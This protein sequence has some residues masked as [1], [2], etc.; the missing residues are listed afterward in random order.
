M[1]L[2]NQVISQI[3]HNIAIHLNLSRNSYVYTCFNGHNLFAA[4]RTAFFPHLIAIIAFLSFT[5]LSVKAQNQAPLITDTLSFCTQP[6]SPVTICLPFDDPNGDP[7]SITGGHTTFN[8]SLNFL[9]DT[10]VRYTPLPAF[11]GTDYVFLTLCDDQTPPACSQAVA[12]VHVGCLPP[13]AHN[14]QIAIAPDMVVINGNSISTVTGYNGVVFNALNNDD[15]VCSG[16]LTIPIVLNAPQNGSASVVGTAMLSYIPDAGFSGTDQFTYIACNNCPLCD[17][18]TVTI[19]VMPTSGTACDKDINDCTSPFNTLQL[20]PEF[21]NLT[22]SQITNIIATPLQGALNIPVDGCYTYIPDAT[23]TGIDIVSFIACSSSGLCDTTF[24]YITIDQSCGSNSPQANNDQVSTSVA[25]SVVIYPLSNDSDPEGG[26]LTM[27]EHTNP[28]HG[29]VTVSGNNFIYTPNAGFTG[30]DSFT[31]TICDPD[32]LCSQATISITVIA[33]C[34]NQLEYCTASFMNPVEICLQFCELAGESEVAVTDAFTT[35]NCSINLLNDTCIRYTPLP[36]FVGTDFVSIIACNGDATHCDTIQVTVSVGCLKPQANNDAALTDGTPVAGNVLSNDVELCDNVLIASMISAP[37][38]GTANIA[39]NGALSYTP[40]AGF[41]GI[42]YITYVACNTCSPPKC[43]TAIVAITVTSTIIVTPEPNILAQPDVVQT[44]YGTSVTI[45][46]LANDIGEDVSINSFSIPAHGAVATTPSGTIIYI[47]A[48]GYSGID[49]FLYQICNDNGECSQTLV[50]VLVLPSGNPPQAPIAHND[51]DSTGIGTPIGIH[52]L[53]NDNDP[54]NGNLLLSSTSTPTAGTASL[55]SG[56]VIN[57]TPPAGFSGIATFTYEV[58]DQQGLCDEAMVAVAV[59]V[60]YNNEAPIAQN[61]TR[62]VAIGIPATVD[63]LAND[64]DPD[65][66]DLTATII[67]IPANG[68]ASLNVGNGQVTYTPNATFEGIDYLVYMLCDDAI[69]ALCDTAYITFTVGNGNLPPAAQNDVA[70]THTNTAVNVAVLNNDEDINNAD[71]EL[72]LTILEQPTNGNAT[73]NGIQINYTPN[74]DFVGT[75]VLTYQICDPDGEC[76]QAT[77]TITVSPDLILPDAQP[78]I[79]TTAPGAAVIIM[80]LG[81]DSGDAITVTSASEPAHGSVTINENG[82]ITYVPDAGYV[83]TDMF[84][85]QICNNEGECDQAPVSITITGSNQAPI[86]VNDVYSVALNTSLEMDVAQNDNDPEGEILAISSV[87]QPAN[88]TTFTT[89]WG[90]SVV[91]MPNPGFEGTDTFNYTICDP[92]GLCDVATVAVTVGAGVVNHAPIA[93]PDYYITAPNTAL[94]LNLTANDTDSDANALSVSNMTTP[95]NGT[96]TNTGGVIS[97]M[98]NSGF[99]GTD[100]FIYT[101]CDNGVPALCDTAY[102]QITITSGNNTADIAVITPEDADISICIDQ[103]LNDLGFDI[104]SIGISLLPQNGSP[105]YVSDDD[106][107]AYS[108]DDNFNGND[109]M[110]VLACDENG[111]CITVNISIE[112]TPMN[113][114]PLPENDSDTTQINMPIEIAVLLNDVEL[115][116]QALTIINATNPANGTLQIN[117]NGTITYTPN[118]GFI[119]IDQ[120]IYTVTD[121]LGWSGTATVTVTV[122]DQQI[123]NEIAAIDDQA[124]TNFGTVIE[125]EVLDNDT[126]ATDQSLALGINENAQ[127]G[128]A[129]IILT[130][131]IIAYSPNEGFSGIDT[132]SYTLCQA[133]VCDTATV[134]V[135]VLPNDTTVDCTPKFATGFSPNND[136]LNDIWLIDGTDCSNN[137]QLIVFNRWG[138]VVYQVENYTNDMAWNGKLNNQTQDLPDGTYFFI[139]QNPNDPSSKANFSGSI[140]VKR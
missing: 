72:I 38:H 52:V 30:T 105:Y 93:Q 110:T 21:C 63:I 37:A 96:L 128:T 69:P 64:S 120:F 106:C 59:G 41:S 117:A 43:D 83:G 55:G 75:D 132:F 79:A 76:D 88:G 47:P 121:P 57:Y 61:D 56:G 80:V 15:P 86:A 133:G 39:Q 44:R 20:C 28:A 127:N 85:Y 23:F 113:D 97:Y 24:A 115:D 101:I 8:C 33:P 102:V 68:T 123:N 116:G 32:N 65:G 136:N 45:P 53:Y 103:Y 2:F 134:I 3:H 99:I 54:E 34:D 71:N 46:V 22:S 98:P 49:Y 125:I 35:F 40:N 7:V 42:D 122:L 87:T 104:D 27:G 29:I 126:Y 1:I 124:S 84:E 130:A 4:T 90:E 114:V 94:T 89:N 107:I 13:Q 129:S 109:N 73:V 81:N 95:S 111:N 119:G 60:A 26:L 66:D 16:S 9:N 108:P 14:D 118:S 12:V 19:N 139:F 135:Q 140:E 100:V 58:C 138:D 131:G 10:C 31:Y 82:T 91:Y 62:N 137:A 74:A 92:Q 77:L 25:T 51:V 17:T 67:A 5:Q 11:V 78:D 6:M 50:S 112:V 36:G 18:A 70:A 48:P